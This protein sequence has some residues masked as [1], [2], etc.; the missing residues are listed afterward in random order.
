[1][2]VAYFLFSTALFKKNG[3]HLNNISMLPNVLTIKTQ[4]LIY[5]IQLSTTRTKLFF[6]RNTKK[7]FTLFAKFFMYL[8]IFFLFSV[9]RFFSNFKCLSD[10]SNTSKIYYFLFLHFRKVKKNTAVCS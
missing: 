7:N 2:L 5:N 3:C 10:S 6:W 9:A 1:M 8:W 4:S